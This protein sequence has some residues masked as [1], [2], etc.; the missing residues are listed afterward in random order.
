LRS[1]Q[2]DDAVAQRE[3]T[4]EPAGVAPAV[5]GV[6]AARDQAIG[7]RLLTSERSAKSAFRQVLPFNWREQVRNTSVGW[8]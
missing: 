8:T 6:R 7:R 4:G 1:S 2:V 3:S 5:I